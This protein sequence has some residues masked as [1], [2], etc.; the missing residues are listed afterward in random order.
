MKRLSLILFCGLILCGCAVERWE[1]PGATQEEYEQ[2][3]TVCAKLATEK[4]PPMM[5]LQDRAES[6]IAPDFTV[7]SPDANGAVRCRKVGGVHAPPPVAAVDDNL[8]D[9]NKVIHAC[10]RQ[11]GWHPVKQ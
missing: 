1:K 2:T 10:L 11:N 5:R 7:C 4:Y 9:R 6:A 8:A 3:K